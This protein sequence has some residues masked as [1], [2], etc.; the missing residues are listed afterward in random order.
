MSLLSTILTFAAGVVATPVAEKLVPK[1]MAMLNDP[2][3]GGLSGLVES[4][5]KNGLEGMI[6]S[7]IGTGENRAVSPE[8]V[9]QALGEA[10]VQQVA[11][12][13]GISSQEASSGLAALLPQLIDK[14][15]PDGKLPEAGLVDQALAAL[16]NKLM[17]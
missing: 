10:K 3:T 9:Q 15:T 6:S 7:W 8:Q 16:K 17:A 1:A 4:F 12:S 13:V 2:Q 14:L 11:Q 5:R